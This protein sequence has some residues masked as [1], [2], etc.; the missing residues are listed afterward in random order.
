MKA[1]LHAAAAAKKAK[2]AVHHSH[3]ARRGKGE[4][5]RHGGGGNSGYQKGAV[6]EAEKELKALRRQAQHKEAGIKQKDEV[7]SAA[8]KLD[9]KYIHA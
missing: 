3:G 4:S 2:H 6:K 9:E 7:S 1:S 5:S 8:L